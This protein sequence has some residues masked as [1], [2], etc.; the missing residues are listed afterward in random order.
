MLMGLKPL[1]GGRKVGAALEF[2]YPLFQAAKG[3]SGLKKSIL[4]LFANGKPDRS[5]KKKMKEY[6]VKYRKLSKFC[7]IYYI[8]KEIL[9]VSFF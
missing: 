9:P 8:I 6:K 3:K 4:F 7:V 5:D 1:G 2:Y